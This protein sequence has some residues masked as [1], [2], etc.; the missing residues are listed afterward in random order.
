[1]R[2]LALFL[3]VLPLGCKD[4]KDS[5]TDGDSD[6]DTDADTDSDTD[7]DTDADTDADSDTDTTECWVSAPTGG[8]CYD[9]TICDLPTTPGSDSLKF[10]NQCS[11]ADWAPFDNATRI[12]ASTW[13]PG[14]ELPDVP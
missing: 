10:L 1:M 13:V 9:T 7:G 12:P 2:A 4:N 14:T 5:A 6:A 3:L 8:L 11:G